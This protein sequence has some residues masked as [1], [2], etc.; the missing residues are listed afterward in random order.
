MSY[1][2]D[3]DY[4]PISEDKS[5]TYN[6]ITIID[7]TKPIIIKTIKDGVYHVSDQH[8]FYT[9][10]PSKYDV[11]CYKFNYESIKVQVVKYKQSGTAEYM[12]CVKSEKLIE[13]IEVIKTLYNTDLMHPVTF[14]L[15]KYYEIEKPV[16]LVKKDGVTINIIGFDNNV[17]A[18]IEKFGRKIG[19]Y[20]SQGQIFMKGELVDKT[21]YI[22]D[23]YIFGEILDCEF[24]ERM[25]KIDL[26]SITL[27]DLYTVKISTVHDNFGEC[28]NESKNMS[29]DGIIIQPPYEEPL[30][31]KPSKFNTVDFLVDNDLYIRKGANGLISFKTLSNPKFNRKLI[32]EYRAK[33]EGEIVELGIDGSFHRNRL[34]KKRPNAINTYMSSL[35]PKAEVPVDLMVH[36]ADKKNNTGQEYIFATKL[37]VI[38]EKYMHGK[39]LEC[40]I[41]CI[42]VKKIDNLIK[43]DNI[44]Q[45]LDE[46]IHKSCIVHSVINKTLL[47]YLSDESVKEKYDTVLIIHKISNNIEQILEKLKNKVSNCAHVI[48]TSA[49]SNNTP[50]INTNINTNNFTLTESDNSSNANIIVYSKVNNEKPLFIFVIGLMGSGKSRLINSIRNYIHPPTALNIINVD[51]EVTKFI[52]YKLYNNDQTYQKIRKLI[53]PRINSHMNELISDGQSIILETTHID[54]DYVNQLKRSHKVMIIICNVS[55]DKLRKNIEMRNYS[56]IRKTSFSQE[57]FDQFQKDKLRYHEM[58]D[59]L[60]EFDNEKGT[61]VMIPPSIGISRLN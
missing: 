55:V 28:Y 61:F 15:Y 48:I 2:Y 36:A 14:D 26:T 40:G 31:W 58:A 45:V 27:N 44:L 41:D 9:S 10:I 29:N 21:I 42:T 32:E 4:F 7:E 30:K 33:Y 19:V 3:L 22:F 49:S 25:K 39:I 57:Q 54:N 50:S 12:M 23:A 52:S 35:N 56:N 11:L 60:Y 51:N 43:K 13:S 18:C 53:D 16:F 34:D 59:E 17:Y 37:N 20:S 38:L 6:K 5:K 1:Y 47:D 46:D 24:T 8:L